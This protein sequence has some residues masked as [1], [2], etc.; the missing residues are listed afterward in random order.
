MV[1][2]DAVLP[3][4]LHWLEK[5][6]PE[7][8]HQLISIGMNSGDVVKAQ[9]L[10]LQPTMAELRGQPLPLVPI[11]VLVSDE[12]DLLFKPP[13]AMPVF[14][15]TQRQFARHIPRSRIDVIHA[16]HELPSLASDRVLAGIEWVLTQ[17]KH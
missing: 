16:G 6:D 10:G 9:W 8:W 13:T 4:S 1:F 5:N 17:T 14:L 11:V 7:H 3:S 15:R 12:P 2:V